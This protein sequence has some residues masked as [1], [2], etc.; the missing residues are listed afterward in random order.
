[1]SNAADADITRCPSCAARLDPVREA[2]AIGLPRADKTAAFV[3][4]LHWYDFL[5][6]FCYVAQHRNAVLARR[7]RIVVELPF[8]AHP[9]IPPHGIAAGPREGPMYAMLEREAAVAG[10]PLHWPPRLPDTR[11]ALAVAEWVRRSQP[12]SFVPLRRNLFAAHFAL[13]EDLGDPKVIDRHA[14]AVGVDLPDVRAALVD[15][16]A[17]DAVAEAG[18]LA[19][20]AGVTGTPAW[21]S[22]R[23]LILGLRSAVEFERL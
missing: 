13:G 6:P 15:G 8:R 14:D 3:T 2:Q 19:H 10:L 20:A 4:V 18:G 9:E 16:R 11:R 1:M 17:A 21:L 12:S 22:G 7:G 23:R 5:C